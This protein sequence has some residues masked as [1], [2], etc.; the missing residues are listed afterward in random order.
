M[1]SNTRKSPLV[2]VAFAAVALA[3]TI[4]SAASAGERIVRTTVFHGDLNLA[5]EAGV[6]VLDQRLVS[7]VRQLCGPTRWVMGRVPPEIVRCR[8]SAQASITPQR[9]IAIARA[10][11]EPVDTFASARNTATAQQMVILAE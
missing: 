4:P 9:R 10:T 2:A 11:G 1:K 8:Q 5:T 7:A 3:A 6:K